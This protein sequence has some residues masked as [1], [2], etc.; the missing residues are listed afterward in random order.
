[1]KSSAVSVG[2]SPTLVIG[3]DDVNRQVYVSNGAENAIYLGGSDVS[4][5]N[6]FHMEKKT[7]I[8]IFL[9]QNESIYGIVASGSYTLT[10]LLPNSD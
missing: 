5:A 1:M 4:T 2:T 6:G 9:P 8:G 7:A 10:I 3:P